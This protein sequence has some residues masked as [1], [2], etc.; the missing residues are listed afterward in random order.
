MSPDVVAGIAGDL[1]V[2]RPVFGAPPFFL[3]GFAITN[4]SLENG[5]YGAE[6]LA[7]D[8]SSVLGMCA[9]RLRAIA[10]ELV[11]AVEGRSTQDSAVER[12]EQDREV[13]RGI[14]SVQ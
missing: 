10:R 4:A 2:P 8:E 9:T 3:I 12:R 5:F 7:D 6:I 14:V 1:K 11:D 13:D